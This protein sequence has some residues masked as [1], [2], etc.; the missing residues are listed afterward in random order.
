[1]KISIWSNE[2]KWQRDNSYHAAMNCAA[3]FY[4][5]NSAAHCVCAIEVRHLDPDHGFPRN[6]CN[7]PEVVLSMLVVEIVLPLPTATKAVGLADLDCFWLKAELSS[8]PI[9]VMLFL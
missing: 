4:L 7:D 2:L 8:R 9:P 3:A 5:A 6:R 1:M